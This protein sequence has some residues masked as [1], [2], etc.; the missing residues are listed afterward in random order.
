MD[1]LVWSLLGWIEYLWIHEGE[2]A[3]RRAASATITTLQTIRFGT[4]G[5]A[6]LGLPRARRKALE[7]EELLELLR[8][9]SRRDGAT[10]CPDALRLIRGHG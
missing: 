7:L 1:S 4:G 8:E 2:E 6:N 5:V 9:R 3:A 10:Y